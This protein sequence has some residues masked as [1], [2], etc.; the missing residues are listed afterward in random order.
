VTR[1]GG[2]I[3]G[4]RG[5]WVDGLIAAVTEGCG[6]AVGVDVFFAA[7]ARTLAVLTFSVRHVLAHSRLTRPSR[8]MSLTRALPVRHGFIKPHNFLIRQL[9]SFVCL[10]G[11]GGGEMEVEI[12]LCGGGGDAFGRGRWA[13]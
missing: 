2:R 6:F 9:R 4:E 5:L 13:E 7:Q 12:R 8:I 3:N 11:G 1:A 10:G